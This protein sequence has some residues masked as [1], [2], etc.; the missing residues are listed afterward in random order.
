MSASGVS[1]PSEPSETEM[2]VITQ[3]ASQQP[4]LPP[5]VLGKGSV[6]WEETGYVACHIMS[7]HVTRLLW[8]CLDIR[9]KPSQNP[10]E[11]VPEAWF[12]GAAGET[13]E[14][15]EFNVIGRAGIFNLSSL[16]SLQVSPCDDSSD[17]GMDCS[18]PSVRPGGIPVFWTPASELRTLYG[19]YSSY[20]TGDAMP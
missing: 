11:E 5:D 7:H 20:A 6:L 8:A 15:E 14:D 12:H 10:E 13:S 9:Q 3:P 19:H 1:A 18:A 2:L 4:P 16:Q 17:P